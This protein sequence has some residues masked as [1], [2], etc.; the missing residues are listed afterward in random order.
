MT[1]LAALWNRD[2]RPP[3]G[4]CEAMLRAQGGPDGPRR[5]WAEGGIALGRA[6][7]GPGVEAGHEAGP[8]EGASGAF[9]LLAD[10][11]LDN[12]SD[13]LAPLGLTAANAAPVGDAR[14][15]MLCLERWGTDVI[16]RFVGDFALALW[17]RRAERLVLARDY[18]GIRPLH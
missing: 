9:T 2:G 17:D 15:M 14:L 4:A 8:V 10:A 11:R 7:F 1:L 5:V 16:G 18:A 3:A 6:A 13:F 12:R